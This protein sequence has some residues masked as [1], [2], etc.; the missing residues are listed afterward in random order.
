MNSLAWKAFGALVALILVMALLLFVPAGTLRYWQ[1]WTFLLVYFAVSLAITFYLLTRD[2]ALLVRRISGGP[3]AEKDPAQKVIMGLISL[4]F[5]ALLV[6]PAI[7]HRLGWSNM[8]WGVTLAGYVLFGLGWL[9]IFFVLREN[10]FS[11]A[12]IE[13]AKGQPV[14]STGPYAWVRHP[15]YL[16]ALVMLLGIPVSLGS[17]WGALI[18][19]AMTPTLIWRLLLEERFL[20]RNL[21]GYSAYQDNVRY[22]LLPRIW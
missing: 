4:G 1:A 18:V 20:R 17:C 13:V 6:L 11:S 19:V 5:I 2:P 12:T 15:M 7:D 14:I 22:R 16:S 8:V 3:F 21:P 10:S 9:G